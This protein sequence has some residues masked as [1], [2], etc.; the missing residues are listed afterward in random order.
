LAVLAAFV[1]HINESEAARWV[2]GLKTLLAIILL[3]SLV[4]L[5]ISG[6]QIIGMAM[7]KPADATEAEERAAM[8]RKRDEKGRFIPRRVE[9][10]ALPDG[11]RLERVK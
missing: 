8:P 6:G 1:S 2:T 11:V 5:S 10:P 9:L 3:E 7:A 4:Y